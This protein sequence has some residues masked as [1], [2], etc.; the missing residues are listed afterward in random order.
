MQNDAVS[1]PPQREVRPEYAQTAAEM[2]AAMEHFES[3]RKLFPCPNPPHSFR[4]GRLI[5]QFRWAS[6]AWTN[7][8]SRG[9]LQTHWLKVGK[10]ENIEGTVIYTVIVGKAS[11]IFGF[12]PRDEAGPNA[13]ITG[14][15]RRPG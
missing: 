9:H 2:I 7:L 6:E 5:W 14:A 11:I 4:L 15:D 10:S 8:S 3:N 1:A 12:V 13:K